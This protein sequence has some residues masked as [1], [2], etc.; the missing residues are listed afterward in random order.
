MDIPEE[1][2]IQKFY[3][4][5]GYP[6]HVKSTNTY[7]GGCP[8]CREGKSWGR[9]SR[10]YYIPKDNVICCHNCGWY[11]NPVNWVLEVEKITFKELARQVETGD[12]EYGIPKDDPVPIVTEDL[13]KDCIDIF[14][15]TQINYYKNNDIVRRAISTVVDRKLHVAKN[16]PKHLYVTTNDY[17][18]KNRIVIP[19]YDKNNKC[20]FYQ[21][22]RI[23]DDGT[24][25]YL[26]KS[27]STKSLF[28]YN[29]ISSSAENVFITEG[30]LDSCFVENSVAV[31]GIQQS[32]N[33]SFNEIQ[34]AQIDRLFLVQRIWLLDNQWNDETSRQKTSKLLEQGECVFIWPKKLNQ[35]KDIN[36]VCVHY[37]IDHVSEQFLLE[38]TYCGLKGLIRLKAIR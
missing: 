11:S 18:H 21:T 22:R 17:I 10:L 16:R 14:D 8:I 29:N 32:S 6:K 20:I 34:K 7:T 4:H 15:R 24:P 12:Y 3:Q 33:N 36:D 38:N 5:A 26:S 23:L 2:I 31:A 25:K 37:D 13:P 27:N 19:F 30:P 28:N 1:Y 9:K 35:H